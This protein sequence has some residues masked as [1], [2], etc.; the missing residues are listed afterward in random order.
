V[1]AS[2]SLE[3]DRGAPAKA[4][5]W[6][7]GALGPLVSDSALD[8][9]LLAANEL[10]TNAVIH[11]RTAFVVTVRPLEG[12]ARVEVLDANPRPPQREDVPPGATS[13]RGLAMI[14]GL[15]LTWGVDAAPGGKVVWV[16]G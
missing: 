15:G 13:G 2:I 6:L 16:R 14:D 5:R 3:P 12:G 4:R 1:V 9:L 8:C 10:V 11:A 7:R